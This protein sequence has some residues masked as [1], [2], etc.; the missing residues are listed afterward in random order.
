MR[1]QR[2]L[3]TKYVCM[4]CFLLGI[5]IHSQFIPTDIKV[6]FFFYHCGAQ[7]SHKYIKSGCEYTHTKCTM[8]A[9][10]PIW[11]WRAPNPGL[12][13]HKRSDGARY[14]SPTSQEA[15]QAL[16]LAASQSRPS[17]SKLR[18]LPKRDT[19]AG[20]EPNGHKPLVP[21]LKLWEKNTW[22][23][24]IQQ[25]KQISSKKTGLLA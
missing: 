21:G 4:F 8:T 3:N 25:K 6:I 14:T 22:K 18:A 23:C 13:G 11:G 16:F 20:M 10:G 24:N 15:W 9:Y 7:K 5:A 17:S 2:L 1:K 12:L 19:L